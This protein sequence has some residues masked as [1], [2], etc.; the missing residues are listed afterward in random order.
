M[1]L[2]KKGLGDKI[3]GAFN[4]AKGE[5]KDQVGNAVNNARLQ[6][7]GKKDKIKGEVQ[8]RIGKS[9]DRHSS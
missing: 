5:V 3:K 1:A 7:D 2:D 9:K 6:A 4:K 8:E